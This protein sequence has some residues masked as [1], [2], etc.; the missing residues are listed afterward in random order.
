MPEQHEFAIEA[1]EKMRKERREDA[2]FSS[3]EIWNYTSFDVPSTKKPSA[4]S[5]LRKNGYIE[6]TGSTTRAVT[7][8]R[9]GSA[10]PEYRFARSSAATTLDPFMTELTLQA[11]REQSHGNL[12]QAGLRVSNGLL[13]RLASSLLAKRFLILTGLSGSGKTKLAHAFA[14]WL[15]ESE[16]QYRLVAVGA[17][18]TTN[19]NFDDLIG[20]VEKPKKTHFN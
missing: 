9:A 10:T 8:A 15:S 6:P 7:A 5:W 4:I 13:L 16:D 18:W 20:S 1:I 19:E 12:T 2:R 3:D 17:D 14:A 11:F